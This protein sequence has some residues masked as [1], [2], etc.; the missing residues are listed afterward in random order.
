MIYLGMQSGD[1]FKSPTPSSKNHDEFLHY[2]NICDP[3]PVSLLIKPC[4]EPIQITVNLF[5][6]IN[7][8]TKIEE[9]LINSYLIVF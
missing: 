8:P 9:E 1:W 2:G 4:F 3:S 5:Q 6:Q 7:H